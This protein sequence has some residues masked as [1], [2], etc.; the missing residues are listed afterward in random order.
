MCENTFDRVIL[1]NLNYCVEVGGSALTICIKAVIGLEQ[2]S[3][4]HFNEMI[5]EK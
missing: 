3:V 2:L 5:D 4:S 1:P